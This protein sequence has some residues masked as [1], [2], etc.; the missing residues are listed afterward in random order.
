MDWS[1]IADLLVGNRALA[2]CQR[3]AV[4]QLAV[5]E[6]FVDQYGLCIHGNITVL[7]LVA[8]CCSMVSDFDTVGFSLPS[9]LVDSL[10]DKKRDWDEQEVGSISRSEVARESLAVGLAALDA[11]DDH[12]DHPLTTRD[13]RMLVRQAVIDQLAD[14]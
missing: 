14:E 1:L 10:D 3:D 4:W 5:A 11:M 7:S 8:D 2:V 6:L 12:L 13:R 9:E